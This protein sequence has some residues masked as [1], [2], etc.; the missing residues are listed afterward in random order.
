MIL[1][2]EGETLTWGNGNVS[3]G[4][5][6]LPG[7]DLQESG[8]SGTIGA[9]QAVAV[10]FCEFNIDIFKQIGRASCRERV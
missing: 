6:Q 5:F 9:D 10:S 4:S 2:Q 7:K 8:L 1:L 3:F